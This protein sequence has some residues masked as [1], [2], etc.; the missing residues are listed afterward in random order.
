[1]KRKYWR[2]HHKW[3][4][5]FIA[6]FLL[7]FCI[8]G[9]LL[10][11][12]QFIKNVNVS[13]SFLPSRY[14]YHNWNGGLLRGTALWKDKVLIYG[15]GG[16][17][18]TDS[19]ASSFADFN[20]GFPT[21]ADYRQICNIVNIKDQALF[22]V[23]PFALYQYDKQGKWKM[24]NVPNEEEDKLTDVSALGD[25]LVVLSR[26]FAYV[27][28]PPYTDFRRI[29]LPTPDDYD[30]EVTAFRTIWLLH[31]GEL[32]GSVGKLVIDTIALVIILLS[33]TGLL[34]W[35]MKKRQFKPAPTTH[36][37]IL[38][39]HNQLGR[40]TIGLTLLVAITGWC[41]RP[42]VMIALVLNK[43]PIIPGT[44]LSNKNPWHDNLRMIRYD[45]NQGDW[46]LSSSNGFYTISRQVFEKE[47]AKEDFKVKQIVHQPPVSVMGLNALEQDSK[48]N[49]LCA[50][51]SGLFVWNRTNGLIT[52]YFTHKSA[53]KTSGA[54]FGKKAISGLSTH[55]AGNNH[56]LVVAEYDKGTDFAAQPTMLNKLPMSLW[57]V[58]LEIHSGRFFIGNIATYIFIFI[59]GLVAIWCLISGYKVRLHKK[60]Q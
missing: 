52:D 57:N 40:W 27:S 24:V 56:K 10:N 43:I 20:Q 39:L 11:H 42:P 36:R 13:R 35:L 37:K 2:K 50:S 9:L 41:L 23:S 7:F 55:F 17:W 46:L 3:A 14:E 19:L 29:N 5:L 47:T 8:S 59:T 51:F 33:I 38:N 53:P 15:N 30:G 60:K 31:S 25:T 34:F 12:R 32:F 58:A 21:G 6:L 45:K 48:G 1:M 28:L 26:S 18:L 22:A 16:V 4:G 49:W 54:P 44:T